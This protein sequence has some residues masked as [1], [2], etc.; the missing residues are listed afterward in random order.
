MT[1]STIKRPVSA[2]GPFETGDDYGEWRVYEEIAFEDPY[3]V[4]AGEHG[5]SRAQEIARALNVLPIAEEMA[6]W[7]ALAPHCR[8]AMNPCSRCVSRS[9]LLARFREANGDG[10]SALYDSDMDDR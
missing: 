7:I 5:R 10:H 9:E 1:E 3:A 2:D 8:I 6:A 4:I